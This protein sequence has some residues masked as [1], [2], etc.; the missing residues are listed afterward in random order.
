[1][2]QYAYKHTFMKERI[3][4]FLFLLFGLTAN[5]QN[6]IS[7]ASFKLIEND[8]TA[9]THGTEVK[10]Q[11]GNTCALIKVQTTQT[12]FTFDVGMMGVMKTEQHTGEIWV[13]VP[14]GVKH[15]SIHHQQLGHLNDYY[16]PCSI[17]SG[18]TYRMELVSGKVETIVKETVQ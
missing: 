13:Y 4:L 11:N 2:F 16:F 18:R 7:V 17:E 1:M 8:L 9:T 5:A 6:T 14:F 12:G 15:I 3:I 10:D